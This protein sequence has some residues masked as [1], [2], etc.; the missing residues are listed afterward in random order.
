MIK[1]NGLRINL[2]TRKGLYGN[3][4]KFAKGLNILRGNNSSGKST[5]FQSILYGIG[6]EEIVGGKNISA[7]QYVLK[8]KI[9]IGEKTLSLIESNVLLEIENRKGDIITIQR[10]IISDKYDPRYIRVYEG[11]LISKS[12][13]SIDYLEM[14]LHDPNAAS[15][16]KFGF[17]AYLEKFLNITLPK[18]N[19]TDGSE[20]K[21]YLQ[22]IFPSFVIEQKNGWSD[23]LSTIPYYKIRDP[24]SKVIEYVLKLDVLENQ[25]KKS[26]LNFQ[27]KVLEHQW[28]QKFSDFEDLLKGESFEVKG[29]DS[30]AYIFKPE[31]HIYVRK[32]V[33]LGEY[34]NID[35]YIEILKK[36]LKKIN[37]KKI[38]T[39]GETMK[40]LT[41]K[42][43]ELNEQIS[44]INLEKQKTYNNIEILQREIKE[45]RR[46]YS[47]TL[48][49]LENY[50][51]YKKVKDFASEENLVLTR[52]NCPTCNQKIKDTLLPQEI[53]EDYMKLD[54]NV[55]HLKA[56]K[57]MYIAFIAGQEDSLI[58]LRTK[59]DRF[60]N[61]IKEKR[62]L[63]KS[64]NRDLVSDD[65][66]PSQFEIEK[67]IRLE[68]QLK[69]YKKLNRKVK[70]FIKDFKTLSKNF[71]EV[72]GK[73]KDL[74]SNFYSSSD[75]EK[76]SYFNK[77]FKLLLDNFNYR[78]YEVND[79]YIPYD[80]YFPTVNGLNLVK[81]YDDKPT[82]K[83]TES[84][85]KYNSSASDFVRAIWAYTIALYKTS[86]KFES[87]HPALLVFDEP[88]QHDMANKDMNS[89]L[90]ELSSYREGQSIVFASFGE[91][92]ENF[93]EET[94]GVKDFH[95]IDFS[96]EKK[97]FKF[98]SKL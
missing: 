29:V 90:K 77:E 1:I 18:V 48:K 65:R 40:R 73:I 43:D 41:K 72:L 24:K 37:K 92:N 64:I 71:S 83:K 49:D 5:I 54:E 3:E 15:N 53:D 4:F 38:P 13:S 35:E 56:Q 61:S 30:K 88:S 19:Y 9:K 70:S 98:Q 63:L 11:A 8:D 21:I 51:A 62:T 34:K 80:N 22:T 69:H 28:E 67:K 20:R 47:N 96:K 36:D 86:T 46:D 87:N 84:K 32:L 94:K 85:L 31:D 17:H 23:F 33:S 68:N 74:P 42:A 50:T 44:F 10:H 79:I 81:N 93:I 25:K 2:I 6:M 58:K 95:L 16:L 27:K 39:T 7:L 52:E 66:I 91:R 75:M 14:Y 82:A 26:K 45:Y 97:I 60:K 12:Q 59:Y 89:F 78:S 76:L 57:E 55:E